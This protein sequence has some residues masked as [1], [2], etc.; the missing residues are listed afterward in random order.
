M[1][2]ENINIIARL[3]NIKQLKAIF[4]NEKRAHPSI[5]QA[6]STSLTNPKEHWKSKITKLLTIKY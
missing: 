6:A 5:S 4:S 3:R 2:S 1:V